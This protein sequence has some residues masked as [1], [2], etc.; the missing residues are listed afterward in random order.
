MTADNLN[1]SGR[2]SPHGRVRRERRVPLRLVRVAVLGVALVLSGC[3]GE[4]EPS[5]QKSGVLHR[6][7]AVAVSQVPAVSYPPVPRPAGPQGLVWDACLKLRTI[8]LT[9]AQMRAS[10]RMYNGADQTR[11]AVTAQREAAQLAAQGGRDDLA[12][13]IDRWTAIIAERQSGGDSLRDDLRFIDATC[14]EWGLDRGLPGEIPAEPNTVAYGRIKA[15]RLIFYGVPDYTVYADGQPFTVDDCLE[16]AARVRG[17]QDAGS[18]YEAT[19]EAFF[20]LT[21]AEV[22]YESECWDATDF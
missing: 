22:C 21:S 4:A 12:A 18:A 8:N 15:C 6:R 19:I 17:V 7:P 1:L 16:T 20:D 2:A 9:F 5:T 13:A 10:L 14:A 11:V 3:G